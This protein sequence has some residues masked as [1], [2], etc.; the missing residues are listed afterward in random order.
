MEQRKS[1]P[2]LVA[3]PSPVG[4]DDHNY[5]FCDVHNA[6][7]AGINNFRDGYYLIFM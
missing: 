7:W 2:I 4:R 3:I 1:Q 5:N 6:I